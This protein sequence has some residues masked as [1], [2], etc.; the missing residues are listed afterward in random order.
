MVRG[1]INGYTVHRTDRQ[2][3]KCKNMSLS[4]LVKTK[5]PLTWL[6]ATAHDLYKKNN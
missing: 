2:D 1:V 3:P 6:K 4:A 5:Q